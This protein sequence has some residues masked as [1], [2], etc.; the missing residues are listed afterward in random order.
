MQAIDYYSANAEDCAAHYESVAFEEVHRCWMHLLPETAGTC[1]DVGAGS[2][3][4]A[5][6]LARRGW[7][8]TA[9]EPAARLRD[10]ARQRHDDPRIR[11]VDDRLPELAVL[12]QAGVHYDL[13]LLSGVWMHVAPK[14]RPRALSVL[15][16]LLEPGALLVLT[17]RYG[18]HDVGRPMFD[19]DG[20]G[21]KL[22]AR[23][24]GLV[25]VEIPE[26]ES[27]DVLGRMEVRWETHA[28]RVSRTS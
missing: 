28:F 13:V 6:W 17:L 9:V 3:R 14:E 20:E 11:W 1:C 23:A 4:D 27:A 16:G 12:G 22:E 25:P 24:R 19:S 21:L 26:A 18:R 10:E 7:S 2:G 8:V 5:G 15:A